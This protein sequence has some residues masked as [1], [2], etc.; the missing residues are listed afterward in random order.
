MDRDVERRARACTRRARAS[1]SMS[2]SS[3]RRYSRPSKGSGIERTPAQIALSVLLLVGAGLLVRSFARLQDRSFGFDTD[4]VVTA[5][6][7]LP[8]DRYASPQQS[9]AFLDRLVSAMVTLPGVESA[10]AVNTLPLTG[11]NA[12]RPHNLPG[13]PPQ[14]RQAE[15][16]M[17]ASV[18]SN[19]GH[20]DSPGRGFDER[21]G[22]GSPGVIV[23]NET[24][25]RRLW[26]GADPVGE[27]LMV[28]DFGEF[29]A[30]QVIGVVGDTRHHDLAKDPEAEIYRPASQA[31]W[32]FFGLVVRTQSTAEGLERT[33]RDAAGRVDSTVPISAVQSLGSLADS[34]W[35]WRRSSMVLL[36]VFLG[37]C[38]RPRVCR[39]IRRDGVRGHRTIAGDRRAGRA[40]CEASRRGSNNPGPGHVA[41]GRRHGER[42]RPRRA[43]WRNVERAPLRHHAAR[44]AD[45]SDRHGSR[46][47]CLPPGDGDTSADGHALGSNSRAEGRVTV[48]TVNESTSHLTNTVDDLSR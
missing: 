42:A 31:Y 13:Q 20:S 19:H 28:P 46:R 29:S 35:A 39:R 16:R 6:L 48:Q 8:R 10:A 21:D 1:T 27:T 33:L 25:A 4:H 22:L 11:F 40:W 15:F 34:T 12:L 2:G 32:P 36:G 5:Q 37:P 7:L 18:L 26:P 17:Y 23:V 3:G 24:A 30:R 14:T 9:G 45:L 47:R 43:C 41:D 44:S 38:M